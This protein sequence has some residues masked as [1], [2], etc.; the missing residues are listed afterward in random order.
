[1]IL[2]RY[3]FQAV[4]RMGFTVFRVQGKVVRVDYEGLFWESEFWV[5]HELHEL[6]E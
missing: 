2:Y 1:M 4:T 3:C 5:F 6:H